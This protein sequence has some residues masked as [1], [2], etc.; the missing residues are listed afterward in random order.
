MEEQPSS[1]L[2][3][4]CRIEK[5]MASL[6]DLENLVAVI[7]R[8]ATA[9]TEAASC[10][11]A[12]YDEGTNELYF[13]LARGEEEE[14]EYERKLRCIRL[15]MGQGVAGWCAVHREAI[16]IRDAYCDPRFH[17]EADEETGFVTRSILAIPMI[18]R[19]KLIGV[20]EAVN[21]QK[22]D[23]FSARDEKVLAVLGAQAALVIENARLYEQN[24]QQARLSA[25]GQGIAG[26]AHCIKNILTGVDGGSYILEVGL[27]RQNM[28]KVAE[29]W[30]MFKRNTGIMK[31]LILDM[32]AY[33]KEREP[34]YEPSDINQICTRVAALIQDRARDK[35]AEVLLD[36]QPEIGPVML[37]PA[38][39][40]RS[41]LNLAGNAVDAL[42]AEGGRV[43][44]ATRALRTQNALEI[45]VADTGCGISE[46]HL[47]K[48]FR[49]FFS[50]KGSKGTGLGLAVTQK[51]IKEHRG[52]IL[53][54]SQLGAGTRFRITL[55]LAPQARR[56]DQREAS[57]D[58]GGGAA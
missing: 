24:L 54:E 16:N 39:I 25:I 48:L 49:A 12:L 19:G 5:F 15:P 43:T 11:V 1:E 46:E 10:S 33:S 41:I 18:R 34:E 14:R 22:G 37:D 17:K 35:K 44:L 2:E 27:R 20:V 45:V 8:E 52:E 31:E 30:E 58:D 42:N 32:L 26:A 6:A 55:P 29:G 36:L 50:T 51:I 9:A 53:V 3:H 57:G 21:K 13:Y 7:I 40:Y 56:A 23:F 28:A 38:G 47:R 4:L